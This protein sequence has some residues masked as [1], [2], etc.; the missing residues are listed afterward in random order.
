M[1]KVIS[2]VYVTFVVKYFHSTFLSTERI[3]FQLFPC[4]FMITVKNKK[5]KFINI[6][7]KAI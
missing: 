4:F 5:G 7:L 6:A 2:C 1:L 3:F